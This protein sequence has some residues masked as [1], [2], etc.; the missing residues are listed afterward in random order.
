MPKF[1]FWSVTLDKKHK[2][3]LEKLRRR[4]DRSESWIVED[5]IDKEYEKLE[6]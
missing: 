5:L 6:A 4:K 1:G 3:K 2:L